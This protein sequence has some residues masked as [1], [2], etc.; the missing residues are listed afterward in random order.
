MTSNTSNQRADLAHEGSTIALGHTRAARSSLGTRGGKNTIQRKE[1]EE[2]KGR[3][4]GRNNSTYLSPNL[5][6][7]TRL[8]WQ[9]LDS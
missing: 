8:K 3:E 1:K 2:E 5:N 7:S 9:P 6:H 4:K